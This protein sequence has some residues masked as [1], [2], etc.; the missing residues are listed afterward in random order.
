[1]SIMYVRIVVR[2]TNIRMNTHGGKMDNELKPCPFCGRKPKYVYIPGWYGYSEDVGKLKCECGNIMSV[3]KSGSSDE[4]Y[5]CLL[6][7]WNERA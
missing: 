1:M 3:E 5:K 2:I 7:R 4:L 6:K